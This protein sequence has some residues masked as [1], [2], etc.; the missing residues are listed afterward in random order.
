MYTSSLRWFTLKIRALSYH[1]PPSNSGE[2]DYL[3]DLVFA[4]SKSLFS[5]S[6]DL[7][8]TNRVVLPRGPWAER[9]ELVAEI[10]DCVVRA[11][12]GYLAVPVGVEHANA[13]PTLLSISDSVFVGVEVRQLQPEAA[14]GL[15][16]LLYQIFEA[17]GSEALT[18]LAL[19]LG[20]LV[21]TP[22]FP[23]TV[24]KREGISLSLLYVDDLRVVAQPNSWRGLEKK[25]RGILA[26]AVERGKRLAE[27]SELQFLGVDPSLSPWMDESVAKLVEDL[28]DGEF[29]SPGTFHAVARL[30]SMIS[31]AAGPKMVGFAEVMLPVAED[32]RLKELTAE[33][34]LRLRD[35]VG[36]S[37]VCVAGLDMVALPASI[38]VKGLA[39]VLV[40]TFTAAQVKGRS[41][42]VRVLI[43]DG[44]PGDWVGLGRFGEVP[45]MEP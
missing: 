39:S 45:V 43:V 21:E 26:Q 30:N 9:S 20:G 42:G 33:G 18:R 6:G 17:Q 3:P 44:R 40:D 5:N 15:A 31:E 36:L 7:A 35:L 41:M 8:W 13:V 34:S 11:G 2:T 24:S 37:M 16:G 10:L 28:T 1:A 38:S 23:S 29:G 22:Y 19:G 25:I 4:R 32:D 27:S 12:A 14:T